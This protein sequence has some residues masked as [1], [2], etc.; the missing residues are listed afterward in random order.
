MFENFIGSHLKKASQ[1]WTDL[2]E[3]NIDLHFLR[4]RMGREVDFIMLKNREPWLLIEVKTA[5]TN[6]DTSLRYFSNKLNIPGIQVINR[7]NYLK[8][9][10]NITI[11][12]ADR[13]LANLP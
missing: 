2:G 12:S 7:P 5:E 3:G 8:E 4:D 6:V 1:L 13:W 9:H 10:G 11:V